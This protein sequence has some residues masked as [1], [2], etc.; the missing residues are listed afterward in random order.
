[1]ISMSL[2]TAASFIDGTLSGLDTTFNGVSIDSR[3]ILGSNLFFAIQGD[4]FDG[5]TFIPSVYDQ[6]AAGAVVEN[7]FENISIP[8]IEVKNTVQA[9]ADLAGK[10]RSQFDIPVIAITGS[11]GKTTVKEMVGSILDINAGVLVTRGN[12]NNHLGVPL[13]LFELDDDH[14]YAV[15]EMGA[16]HAG[17]IAGLCDIALPTVAVITQCAPAHL[18]GF[19]T[20]QGVAQAKSEIFS[21]LSSNGTAIINADDKYANLWTQTAAGLERLYFGIEKRADISATNIHFS[22]KT[23][24][25]SFDI[26]FPDAVISITFSMMGSHNILNSLAAAACCYAMGIPVSQIKK[27]LEKVESIPGRMERLT[28]ICDS[29]IF[30][31]T[32]NANPSSVEAGL[33]VLAEIH[34][35]RWM[36]FGDMGELGEQAEEF[37]KLMGKLARKYGIERLFTVGELSQFSHDEFGNGGEHF[38]STGELLEKVIN[39][40]S[41]DITVL[42]KG[43][44]FMKLEQI[45]AGLRKGD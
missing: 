3:S 9:M 5:H 34:G 23:A 16:N 2:S 35:P 15:I 42:V 27:G 21:G 43:S 44:R 41:G 36:I 11:N 10:W 24:E 20:E 8:Q 12:L 28:G 37:H 14:K 25:T 26:Q 31:D 19:K 40:L 38:D 22:S 30:N 45:V 29:T 6:G 7:R 39:E 18:E 13:T 32:Y 4:R 17:D 1:V 33:K